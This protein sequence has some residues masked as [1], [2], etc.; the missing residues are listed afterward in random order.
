MSPI[1]NTPLLPRPRLLPSGG[2]G[3]GDSTWILASPNCSFE[4]IWPLPDRRSPFFTVH[5]PPVHLPVRS[6]SLPPNNTTAS[7][8]GLPTCS[9]VLGVGGVMISGRGRFSS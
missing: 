2:G 7:L 1:R 3:G 4:P 5:L 9:C 6:S 8:G